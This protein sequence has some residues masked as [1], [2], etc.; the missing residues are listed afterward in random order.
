MNHENIF[1][2]NKK[3]MKPAFIKSFHLYGEDSMS[4]VLMV[5]QLVMC[6]SSEFYTIAMSE[7]FYIQNVC[8]LYIQLSV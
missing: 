7:I 2:F 4:Y 1:Y 3:L 8:F 6:S 5:I